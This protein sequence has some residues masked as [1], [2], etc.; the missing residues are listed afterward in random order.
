MPIVT[1][2]ITRH[3]PIICVLVGVSQNR[4][5]RLEAN[6]FPVPQ[7]VQ[8]RALIDTGSHMTGMIP[9]VFRSLEIG[10]F[11]RILVR[12][13]STTPDAPFQCDQ[14]DVTLYLVSGMDQ[15]PFRGVHAIA[16]DDF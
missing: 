8:V 6:G 12:T 13:P 3:G 10:P 11:G 15:Y 16:S 9:D 7:R 4:Q 14:Y 1:G 5:T 2:E